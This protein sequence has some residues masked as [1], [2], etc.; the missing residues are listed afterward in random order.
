MAL[1]QR[2]KGYSHATYSSNSGSALLGQGRIEEAR[3]RS[4][5][6]SHGDYL[7]RIPCY[8]RL[9]TYLIKAHTQPA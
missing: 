2:S 9:S 8:L 7:L 4:L 6:K 5:P 1:R 3:F